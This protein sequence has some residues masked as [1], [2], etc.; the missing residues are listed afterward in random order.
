[1]DTLVI[2]HLG[3]PVSAVASAYP[4]P[5]DKNLN[6]FL[7]FPI[8]DDVVIGKE[9]TLTIFDA[10][11]KVIYSSEEK[12]IINNDKRVVKFLPD[13]LEKGVYLFTTGRSTTEII[14]KFVIKQS[15]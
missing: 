8:A 3:G 7:Y 2:T 10:N 5:F 9:I 13:N 12:S 15:N 6:D 1:M 11:F 14:G 4:Q